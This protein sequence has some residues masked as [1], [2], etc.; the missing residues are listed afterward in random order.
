M[1]VEKHSRMLIDKLAR[2]LEN[3]SFI[4]CDYDLA[5]LPKNVERIPIDDYNKRISMIKP[6][7]NVF[8]ITTKDTFPELSSEE[9]KYT[10]SYVDFTGMWKTP[11]KVL[12][13]FT[14]VKLDE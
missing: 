7:T 12:E 6:S 13:K 1:L 4:F 3:V 8:R 5:F 9:K 11:H 2:K 10:I 14:G